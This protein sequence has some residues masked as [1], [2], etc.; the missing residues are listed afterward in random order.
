MQLTEIVFAEMRNFCCELR[1][2][3][4]LGCFI[5]DDTVADIASSCSQLEYLCLSSCTQYNTMQLTEIV[6]A[7]MRNFCCELR[8]VNLLGCFITDDTVA[9]IASSCSQLEYLC[10][11]SCTQVTDRALISL[12]NGCH[13]DLELSGCSLL[14]DHGFGILAKNCHELERMDLEDCS[15]LTD[16]TLDNFSKGCPCLLNL[17]F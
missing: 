16:I 8:T 10:L 15:L 9:D 14:T 11:S 17:E 13:R 5:T 4:L 7:E 12:A 2:V 3:N 6:F 1:T